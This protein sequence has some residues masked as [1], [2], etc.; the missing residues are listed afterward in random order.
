VPNQAFRAK[1]DYITVAA[2]NDNLWL[3][4][5][6]VLKRADLAE[7]PHYSTNALRVEHRKELVPVLAEE[8]RKRT[9]DEWMEDL[10]A[11]GV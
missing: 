2:A 1:D 5:C 9:R 8:F 4:L 3:R 10:V 6:K 11:D 7:N